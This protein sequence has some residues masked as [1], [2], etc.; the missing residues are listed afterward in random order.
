MMRKMQA[1]SLPDLVNM[2]ARLCPAEPAN[3]SAS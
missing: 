1:A 3:H 2:A